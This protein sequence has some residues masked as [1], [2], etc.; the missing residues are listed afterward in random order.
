MEFTKALVG[1][2]RALDTYGHWSRLSDE[3]LVE[4]KYIKK[5]SEG[6]ANCHIKD[7]TAMFNIKT[8]FQTIATEFERKTG[9]LSNVMM[10]FSDEGFGRAVVICDKI[11]I[12]DKTIRDANNYGYKTKEKL[13]EEGSKMFAKAL[14]I[15][16][17]YKLKESN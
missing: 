15:Y 12:C 6:A 17:T 7:E 11:V 10:E 1:Q 16:E 4:K 13:E 14:E 5:K 9:E 2:L 3:E 8:F